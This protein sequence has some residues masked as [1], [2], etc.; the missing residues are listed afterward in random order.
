[1]NTETKTLITEISD[2]ME[3]KAAAPAEEKSNLEATIEEL[4]ASLASMEKQMYRVP[5]GAA[6]SE[7]SDDVKAF[8]SYLRTKEEK[9]LRT[10]RDTDGGY[11]V[12]QDMYN[13]I[14]HK[15]IEVSDFRRLA[16]V[17]TISGKSLDVNTNESDMTVYAA[18]EGGTVTESQPGYGRVTI[19]A[20]PVMAEARMTYEILNDSAFDMIGEINMRAAQ[21]FA[22]F[23]GAAFINGNG[24]D[25][26]QGILNASGMT[27]VNSGHATLLT[28]DAFWDML[29]AFK[30][31]NPTFIMNR[32]T[33]VAAR[34]LKNGQGEYLL[35]EGLDGNPNLALGNVAGS[36]AGVPVVLMQD[37]PAIGASAVPVVLGDF[38]EA[39]MIVERQGMG[40]IRDDYTLASSRQVKFVMNRRLGGAVVNPDALVTM[41]ISA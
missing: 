26:A 22:Q 31:R 28:A 9:Y 10:D 8:D 40:I 16:R 35:D 17:V 3:K 36:I 15:I 33:Y 7:R 12:P 21:K 6:Q 23:E 38:Q 41:T 14:I 34:K 39:Y 27:N 18:G 32:A 25:R 5:S 20:H 4:K 24:V 37:M 2:L 11:L 19:P 29:A 1:M 13:Q 30:Y